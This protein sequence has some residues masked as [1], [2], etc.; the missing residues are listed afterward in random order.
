MNQFPFKLLFCFEDEF[1]LIVEI[2]RTDIQSEDKSQV[3]KWLQIQKENQNE[4]EECIRVLTFQSMNQA[5]GQQ[6][7]EFAEGILTWNADNVTFN[8]KVMDR[9]EPE[10][11]ANERLELIS[12]FLV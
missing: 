5:D 4:N 6:I 12:R 11:L 1:K 8:G 7:R 10:H 2:K 3:Y 9:I